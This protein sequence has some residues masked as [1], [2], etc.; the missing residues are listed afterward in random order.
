[1][2]L[3]QGKDTDSRNNLVNESAF[4]FIENFQISVKIGLQF[5]TWKDI[6]KLNFAFKIPLSILASRL[7]LDITY[8][9]YGTGTTGTF[10]YYL[11]KL[12]NPV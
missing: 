9:R 12:K 11:V 6:R 2:N 5:F 3:N 4:T 10:F 1:M 8:R 7:S